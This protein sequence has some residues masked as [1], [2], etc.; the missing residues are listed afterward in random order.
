MSSKSAQ[1][2]QRLKHDDPQ[3]HAAMLQKAKERNK[4]NREL[5]RK[6]W[7]TEPQTRGLLQEKENF[8][9]QQR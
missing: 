5:K 3:K 2:W 4:R 1:Y 6:K 8:M 9:E 7:E